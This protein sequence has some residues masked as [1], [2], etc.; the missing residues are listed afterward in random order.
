MCIEDFIR[1]IEKEF[2]DLAPGQLSP[3]SRYK[4]I[5]E[6]NSIN[7]LILVAMVKTEYDITLSP[8]DLIASK[9]IRDIFD[10]IENRK[11]LQ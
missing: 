7:A 1:K 8:A 10:I 4:E 2:D 11:K 5:F 3:E 9:T 6:W